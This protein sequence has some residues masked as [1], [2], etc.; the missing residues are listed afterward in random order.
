M[1]PAEALLDVRRVP[2]THPDA[3][4][5]IQAV[6]EI[7]VRLYGTPDETPYAP[8]DFEQPVGAFFVAYDND[9]PIAMGGWRFRPDV[10][11]LRGTVAAE[12]KRMYVVPAARG[13]GLARMLLS[14]LEASARSAGAEVMVLETG[15]P[16]VEA[17]ALYRSAGY[18]PVEGFGFYRDEPNAH[19]FGRRID[20]RAHE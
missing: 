9:D 14:H 8:S 6:Q 20:E 2:I 7:Y 5:L 12:V 10:H 11:A 3:V 1:P 17:I 19:Y 18:V 4:L 16:Q 15:A 13:R